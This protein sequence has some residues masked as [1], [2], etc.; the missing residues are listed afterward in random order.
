ML[1]PRLSPRVGEAARLGRKLKDWRR[2]NNMK[3]AGLASLLGVSQPTVSRWENGEDLPSPACMCR[4]RDILAGSLR[5]ECALERLLIARQTSIRALLDLDGMRLDS[6][7]IGYRQLWP[8]FS[9]LIGVPLA[10]RL[11][12]EARLI[13]DD[14]DLLRDI[15]AGAVGLVSGVSERHLDIDMDEAI[16]HRWHICFR[17]YGARVYADVVFEPCAAEETAGVLDLIRFDAF[18][19]PVSI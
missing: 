2:L 15:G 1:T 12:N 6:V 5:D 18:G 3:Q 10:D 4:L 13:L 11:I 17:R 16:K 14:A 8:D 7:S 19:D 9:A